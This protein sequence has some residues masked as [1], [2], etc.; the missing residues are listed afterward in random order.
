[1]LCF[2]ASMVTGC[3]IETYYG[4]VTQFSQSDRHKKRGRRRNPLSG[5]MMEGCVSTDACVSTLQPNQL[6]IKIECKF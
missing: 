5:Q 1:M 2:S 4:S 3:F 6:E